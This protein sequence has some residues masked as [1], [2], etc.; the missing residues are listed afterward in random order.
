[1]KVL[2]NGPIDWML[3]AASATTDIA[4]RDSMISQVHAYVTA[5]LENK[6]FPAI[7]NPNNGSQISGL[8][9]PAQGAIFAPLALT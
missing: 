6:P 5:N 4:V 9:S 1:M 2:K 7:Y 8:N 3:F